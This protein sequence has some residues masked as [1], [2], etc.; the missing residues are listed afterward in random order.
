VVLKTNSAFG[1]Y[2]RDEFTTLKEALDRILSTVIC[3]N[4]TFRQDEAE[5][6]AL[7]PVVRQVILETFAAHDSHSVQQTL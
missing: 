1:D 3:A 7:W 6:G 5:P 2:L 4:W